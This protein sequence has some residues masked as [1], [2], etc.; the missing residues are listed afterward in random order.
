[1]VV[2]RLVVKGKDV[3]P[4]ESKKPA[5]VTQAGDAR[6]DQGGK[7][8][9]HQG[10]SGKRNLWVSLRGA[11]AG[12]VSGTWRD[13]GI[14]APGHWGARNDA[15]GRLSLD[16]RQMGGIA[17]EVGMPMPKALSFLLKSESAPTSSKKIA[18][19]LKVFVEG[20]SFRKSEGE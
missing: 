11:K 20:V 19:S 3:G 5:A 16:R 13:P 8:P 1:M 17:I 18:M 10:Q 2:H 15:P 12:A 9:S 4:G 7:E 6:G 14:G